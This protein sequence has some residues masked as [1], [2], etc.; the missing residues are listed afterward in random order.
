L[1]E[2]EFFWRIG[3][4]CHENSLSIEN[5]NQFILRIKIGSL[6]E[7]FIGAIIHLSL[8]NCTNHFLFVWIESEVMMHLCW[9]VEKVEK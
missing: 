7:V 3:L 5:V 8:M 9:P 1:L 6:R 4:D 2:G